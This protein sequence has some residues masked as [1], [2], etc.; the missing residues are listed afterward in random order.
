MPL[1][2]FRDDL[3]VCEKCGREFQSYR[4]RVLMSDGAEVRTLIDRDNDVI[5]DLVKVCRSC[6]TVF[7][8]HTKEA[9]IKHNSAVYQ[10]AFE[11]LMSH[12]Q[13]KD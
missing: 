7:H 12:Y 5:Y 3:V 4:F 6:S 1:P 11:Q 13:K 10:T 8:W 9:A 2:S